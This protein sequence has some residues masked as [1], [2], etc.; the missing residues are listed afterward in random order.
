MSTKLGSPD[1]GNK[2]K[3]L[4]FGSVEGSSGLASCPTII[5]A[6]ISYSIVIPVLVSLETALALWV[7][8]THVFQYQ[9]VELMSGTFPPP[10]RSKGTLVERSDFDLMYLPCGSLGLFMKESK[11]KREKIPS[12]F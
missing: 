9:F 8:L 4:L 3:V 11:D 1:G 2:T 6:S 10:K 12:G 7:E 5:D